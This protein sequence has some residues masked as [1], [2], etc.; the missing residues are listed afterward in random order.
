MRKRLEKPVIRMKLEV[1]IPDL[2]GA[3]SRKF[4]VSR[5]LKA[6]WSGDPEEV[7][8]HVLNEIRDYKGSF[9]GD[10]MFSLCSL[11]KSKGGPIREESTRQID[12]T[13]WAASLI[14]TLVFVSIKDEVHEGIIDTTEVVEWDGSSKD[15]GRVSQE[16]VNDVDMEKLLTLLSPKLKHALFLISKSIAKRK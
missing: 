7:A 1:E 10:M 13:R 15:I 8:S 6:K 12:V 11:V 2:E 16:E 9:L 5:T 14:D 3:P 4:A